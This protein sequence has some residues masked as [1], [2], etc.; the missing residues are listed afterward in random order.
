MPAAS[1]ERDYLLLTCEHGGHRIPKAYTSLF[2]G[3]GDVLASHRGWDPGA[4]ELARR[5][6][7]GLQRPLL[8]VTWSRL[9]V[10]SNRTP[11]NRKIWSDFTAPLPKEE[12]ARI[13]ERWWQPHRQAV[14][15]AVAQPIAHGQ[16]VVHVAVHSFTPR[17]DGELRNA[18]IGL[19]Y[20]S[21]RVREAE[22]CRHWTAILRTLEPTLRV[23]HNYPY[24]GT[25]DGL[26][27]W[28]RRRHPQARYLGIELEINQALVASPRWRRLQDLIAI[29]LN[30]LMLERAAPPT[31]RALPRTAPPPLHS[32]A[33]RSS[34]GDCAPSM[35]PTGRFP[36]GSDRPSSRRRSRRPS[37]ARRADRRPDPHR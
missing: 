29:S 11:T 28:L 24:R 32:G 2:R 36:G 27:T 35:A 30:A 20:D 6:A 25:A 21:R 33:R 10:E 14:A 8:A 23:R 37:S 9:F 7:R 3:A 12:R 18:D 5:L 13:L 1:G 26:T 15:D 17:L 19:L 16:R 34:S 31:P 22:L 4:L